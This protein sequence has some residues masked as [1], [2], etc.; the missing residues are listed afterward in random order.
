MLD[1]L[2]DIFEQAAVRYLNWRKPV[3][4]DLW[5]IKDIFRPEGPEYVRNPGVHGLIMIHLNEASPGP[6]GGPHSSSAARTLLSSPDKKTVLR[7]A[8][9]E[10]SD[11]P[12]EP[13]REVSTSGG[14]MYTEDTHFGKQRIAVLVRRDAQNYADLDKNIVFGLLGE[15]GPDGT[16]QVRK[17]LL[18]EIDENGQTRGTYYERLSPENVDRALEYAKLCTAQL[19]AR[20][21]LTPAKNLARAGY[22]LDWV[23]PGKGRWINTKGGPGSNSP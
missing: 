6:R 13:D 3:K 7:A 9:P 11:I 4:I 1:T 18:P 19:F 22:M 12:A 20:Q 8:E 21:T 14:I 15:N 2:K 16:F 17:I 5:Q 10:F 23:R